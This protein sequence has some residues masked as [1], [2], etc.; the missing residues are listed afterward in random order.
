MPPAS[1]DSQESSDVDEENTSK[2]APKV[3]DEFPEKQES[4]DSGLSKGTDVLPSENG[5]RIQ[6]HDLPEDVFG[7]KQQEALEGGA[8]NGVKSKSEDLVEQG[9]GSKLERSQT[10][11]P[12]TVAIVQGRRIIR[13]RRTMSE[14]HMKFD[15]NANYIA[16]DASTK[17][18]LGY[19]SENGGK[20]TWNAFDARNYRGSERLIRRDILPIKSIRI[21]QQMT[22]PE[23][24]D[25]QLNRSL[26][27]LNIDGAISS[28]AIKAIQRSTSTSNCAVLTD[29]TIVNDNFS[30]SWNIPR[31]MAYELP[32][33]DRAHIRLQKATGLVQQG[34]LEDGCVQKPNGHYSSTISL[35]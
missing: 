26:T 15:I 1:D 3:W 7:D 14:Q 29:S 22:M 32:A 10:P 24:Y 8:P 28:S 19:I 12:R 13:P 20:G 33:K 31:K 4:T 27:Q 23:S 5:N 25:K 34:D 6:T 9:E 16:K 2:L 18:T 35:V 30:R 11:Q 21:N 17:S